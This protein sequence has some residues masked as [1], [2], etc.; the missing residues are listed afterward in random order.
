VENFL[1]ARTCVPDITL[2]LLFE[3]SEQHE[4]TS[5]WPTMGKMLEVFTLHKF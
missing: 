3:H 4:A 2:E 1:T 5:I